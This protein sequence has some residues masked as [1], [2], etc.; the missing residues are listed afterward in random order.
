M[1][2]LHKNTLLVIALFVLSITAC[3]KENEL[4]VDEKKPIPASVRENS[5][6]KQSFGTALVKAMRE[7]QNL[8]TFVK[9]EALKKFDNDYDILYQLVRDVAVDGNQTF[10]QI[11]SKYFTDPAELDRI[12]A[13]IPLLT[14]FVPEL[15]ENSFS[16]EIWDAVNVAPSVGITFRNTNDVM[17]IQP[18]ESSFMLTS[19]KTPGFPVIVVK[20]NERVSVDNGGESRGIVQGRRFSTAANRFQF[21]HDCFDASKN[22]EAAQRLTFVLD[23]KI[24]DAYTMYLGTDGWHRDYI[25]YG[26]TPT[27][28]NGPFSY[29][30][31]EHITQFSLAGDAA[32][33]YSKISDQTGDPT[34]EHDLYTGSTTTPP[35]DAV[36]WSGG[37][38]EFRVKVLFNGKNG[39]GS[40]F[41]TYFSALPTEIFAINWE[42]VPPNFI[43]LWITNGISLRAK[44][45]TLPIF[46]WDLNQYAA[47]IKVDIEEVDQTELISITETD[48]VKFAANFG[49][50]NGTL[51]K[52]GLKFGASLEINQTRTTVRT[53]TI[54][55][56][57]LGSLLINF[58]DNI[59]VSTIQIG[60]ATA[61]RTRNYSSGQF[62]LCMEPLRVQ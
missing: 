3:R 1:K 44:N 36:A 60:P 54:G 10:R 55:S 5:E 37:A 57:P 2:V 11:L 40:D 61:Y 12:E 49:I 31:Q 14:I 35:N 17:I 4:P 20:E 25:Y 30:F 13:K 52:I 56:D 48:N 43:P 24:K 27:N 18:D 33:M 47:T 29:D 39:V 9:A 26:I 62:N 6:M 58:A 8:R 42:K 7:N 46:N 19:E 32:A 34:W 51:K 28:P 53:F 50:D 23:Q 41:I 15:P 38:F 59:I 21:L 16:A 22:T 45:M